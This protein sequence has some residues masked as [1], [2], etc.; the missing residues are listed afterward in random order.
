MTSKERIDAALSHKQ[1]DRTPIFE[2]V[3]LSPVADAMLGRK[4]CYYDGEGGNWTEYVSEI[5]WE[6]ALRN[7]AHNRVELAIRLGHDLMYVTPNPLP[8]DMVSEKKNLGIEIKY[9]N[10]DPVEVIKARN[11]CRLF[12]PENNNL[13]DLNFIIYSYLTQ[14]MEQHGVDLDLFVPAYN[15]GVWTD[16][17]LMQT[18]ILDSD[19]AYEH[20]KLCTIISLNYIDKYKEF[21]IRHIGVG[22]DF[23][24]NRPVISPQCYRDYIVPEI[25]ELSARIHKLGAWAINASDGNLWEV[26]DD[27]LIGT[28]V[29][30]YMEIDMNAGM[31][32]K[33][34]KEL[35][36]QRITFYGNMD[37]GTVL[38]FASEE[39]IKMYTI[40][41]I[42]AGMSN[43]GHIFTA[44]NAITSSVSVKN[45]LAMVNAYRRYFKL[46]E[47]VL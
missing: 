1:P 36:G 22:G 33:K 27:F 31:D 21:G 32:L 17:D 7:Y 39:E 46:P 9:D 14:E 30:A 5:G 4:F 28:N 12:E 47:I 42:E 20:F 25:R 41:C 37:C 3:L 13:N 40:E 15:H 24:G 11:K 23:A 19:T 45:Y 29:D 44:S 43:G 18:M 26:I 38:S 8:P 35:Y 16:T 10:N 34:L 6:R 2:Y